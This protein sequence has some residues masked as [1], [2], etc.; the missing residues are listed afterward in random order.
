MY[1]GLFKGVAYPF[2]KLLRAYTSPGVDGKLHFT[3]FLVNL[4][5]KVDHKVDQLVLVHLLRVEVCDEETDIV[6]LKIEDFNV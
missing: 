4:L 3:D 5:H 6:A 2:Q 1:E